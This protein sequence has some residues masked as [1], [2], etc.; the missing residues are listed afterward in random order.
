MHAFFEERTGKDKTP[1]R[2]FVYF[3]PIVAGLFP[4]VITAGILLFAFPI[5][6][7]PTTINR[8]AAKLGAL[9]TRII[10]GHIFP[11]HGG[12]VCIATSRLR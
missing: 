11:D 8:P 5:L 2:R 3:L 9:G 12:R 4:G 6:I 7:H 10:R 1:V